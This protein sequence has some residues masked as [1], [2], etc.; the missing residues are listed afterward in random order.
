MKLP[1]FVMKRSGFREKFDKNLISNAI[2]KAFAESKEGN[3]YIASKITESVIEKIIRTFPHDVP[4]VESIQ[5]IVEETLM[6]YN[7]SKTA[8]K[9]ILYRDY[10]TKQRAI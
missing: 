1:K 2:L 4:E 5:D 6:D 9:Y 3:P 7:F 10:R 8:K